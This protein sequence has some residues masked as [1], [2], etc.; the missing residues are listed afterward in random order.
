LRDL[1]NTLERINNI[2]N[3]NN[4]NLTNNTYNNTYQPTNLDTDTN[5]NLNNN[6]YQA[7]NINSDTTPYDTTINQDTNLNTDIDTNLNN[8]N[9]DQ[10]IN[11]ENTNNNINTSP[12]DNIYYT[13]ANYINT[14]PVETDINTDPIESSTSIP[15]L[16]LNLF[17]NRSLE[18]RIRNVM[19]ELLEITVFNN[20]RR[21]M[22][23]NFR[24][25]N[26]DTLEDVPIVPSLNTI[27]ESSEV[28]LYS[29]GTF[30]YTSC[31]ICRN[32]FAENEIIRKLNNCN[33][34]FHMSCIDTWFES[35]IRCPICRNDLRDNTNTNNSVVNDIDTSSSYV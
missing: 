19:P 14:N 35:N 18:R 23:H 6:T 25:S 28:L 16:D 32:D 3:T 2:T 10:N 11:T 15:Q 12:L 24:D 9:Q 5:T 13:S 4:S 31:S 22:R 27:R 20:N 7:E 26:T 29:S 17:N 21:I 30:Q 34:I 33:H 8:T 1:Q